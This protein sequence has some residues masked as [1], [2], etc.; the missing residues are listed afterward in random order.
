MISPSTIGIPN[1]LEH[2]ADTQSRYYSRN[3]FRIETSKNKLSLARHPA[4]PAA[5]NP[6]LAP[7]TFTSH[8]GMPSRP[9]DPIINNFDID[10]YSAAATDAIMVNRLLLE[11][12]RQ[13]TLD[14]GLYWSPS[15]KQLLQSDEFW[16]GGY[17]ADFMI[18][19]QHRMG[20]RPR[21]EGPSP[22]RAN[23]TENDPSWWVCEQGLH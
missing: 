18:R 13:A 10:Y 12:F 21:Q 8:P 6:L 3:T 15:V 2:Y 20:F 11:K 5:L 9:P 17:V 7:R 1:L 22:T 23:M 4:P 16:E 14:S 19:N